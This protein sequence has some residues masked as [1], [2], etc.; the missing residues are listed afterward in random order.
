VTATFSSP[1]GAAEQLPEHYVPAAY[2]EWGVELRDWQSQ[3]SARADAG[4]LR[5]ALR[6]LMPTVGCEADAVAFTQEEEAVFSTEGDGGLRCAVAPDGSYAHGPEDISGAD[7]FAASFESCLALDAPGWRLRAVHRL[8]R[9]GAARAW[10]CVSVELHRE[11]RDGPWT[12][13]QELAGCGGGLEAFSGDARFDLGVLAGAWA[14]DGLRFAAGA[15]APAAVAAEPWSLAALPGELMALP[16]G[17]FSAAEV[18][19]GG[20]AL[21]AAGALLPDGRVRLAVRE[22]R[23]GRFVLA[24]LLTLRRA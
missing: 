15:A 21:L 11:R 4:G 17:A 6:R 3:C 8:A 19:E 16:L 7:V 1:D 5:Y 24:E 9:R 10:R 12:G 2:R 20:D 18:G 22:L 14:A 13:R 23:G